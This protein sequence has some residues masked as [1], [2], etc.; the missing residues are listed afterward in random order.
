MIYK[1]L[2]T[3]FLFLLGGCSSMGLNSDAVGVMTAEYGQC[4]HNTKETPR[5]KKKRVTFRCAD[6]RVLLGSAYER[7]GDW[8]ID[9]GILVENNGKFKLKNKKRVEFKYGI[10]SICNLKPMQ[11][12]GDR[13]I[14]RYYFETK[15]KEC[16]PFI[17]HGD[18]GFV[19][20]KNMDACEQFCN[21]KYQG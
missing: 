5:F 7:K 13:T 17:W 10:D 16:R 3:V 4:I 2:L 9:S 18:G 8:Y 1:V 11:G 12:K 21:Y 14:K 19:P 15:T 6:D 20:F